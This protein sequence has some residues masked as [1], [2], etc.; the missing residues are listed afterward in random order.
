M[1]GLAVGLIVVCVYGA[2]N[3]L[4]KVS[5]AIDEISGASRRAKFQSLQFNK[6]QTRQQPFGLQGGVER[7]L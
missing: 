7:A 4:S 1:A 3:N 6:T 5:R 2:T